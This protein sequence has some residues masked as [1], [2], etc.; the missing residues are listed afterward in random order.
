M[1]EQR[2]TSNSGRRRVLRFRHVVLA[3]VVAACGGTIGKRTAGGESHFLKACPGDCGAGLECISGVCTRG[4]VVGESECSDLAPGAT[5]TNQSIEPGRVAVCDLPC[6]R[7][8]DCNGLGDE[9]RCPAGFCRAAPAETPPDN[10]PDDRPSMGGGGGVPGFV[11]FAPQC[12]PPLAIQS[13]C[14][15]EDT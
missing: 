1:T 10:P 14:S 12:D 3:L 5:C 4:C 7:D 15:F 11:P 13:E 9:F 2:G 6:D 8:R